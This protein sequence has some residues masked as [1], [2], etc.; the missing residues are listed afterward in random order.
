LSRFESWPGSFLSGII[1]RSQLFPNEFSFKALPPPLQCVRDWPCESACAIASCCAFT[2][3]VTLKG[4]GEVEEH[5]APVCFDADQALGEPA[6]VRWFL[7]WFDETPRNEMRP[8][9]LVE[10]DAERPRRQ[11]VTT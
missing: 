1:S 8:A 4:V 2:D 7:N 6:A 3:N 9:L 10:V 5:F 11:A